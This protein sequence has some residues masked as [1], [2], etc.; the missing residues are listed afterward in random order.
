ML[1]KLLPLEGICNI[2]LV[3]NHGDEN[4]WISEAFRNGIYLLGVRILMLV[5]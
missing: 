4:F 2:F 3:Y 1:I 5:S